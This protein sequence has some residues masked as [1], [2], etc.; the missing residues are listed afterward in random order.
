MADERN[1]ENRNAEY[2][3]K[4]LRALIE[5]VRDDVYPSTTQMNIIEQTLP[6]EWIPAYLDVLIEKI[7]KDR[8]P[9]PT[10][11]RRIAALVENVPR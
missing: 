3:A 10:M 11:L 6:R 1:R 8:H 5:H 4:Y 7:A 2:R 9:S